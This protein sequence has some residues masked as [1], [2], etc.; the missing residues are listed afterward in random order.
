[1]VIPSYIVQSMPVDRGFCS[2]QSCSCLVP[3]KHSEVYTNHKLAGLSSGFLLTLIV[4]ISPLLV[5]V[6]H[7][8]WC[9]FQ[10]GIHILLPLCQGDNCRL[11][12]PLPRIP[13]F[14]SLHLYFLPSC[15]FFTSCL[16]TVQS[17]FY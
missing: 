14:S 10:R 17:A 15:P 3:K 7:M 13:L 11:T 8:V 1:M 4:Y 6:S 2:A 9:L 16:A 5:H 12:F